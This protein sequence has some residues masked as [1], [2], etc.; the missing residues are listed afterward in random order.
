[1]LASAAAGMAI[2]TAYRLPAET[3]DPLG[4][5]TLIGATVLNGIAS[6]S[7]ALMLQY[8][9]AEFLGLTTALRLLEIARPDAP[10]LQFFL[11]NAPGTYQHSL[12]VA[13]LAE[14]AAEKLG[15]DTLLVRV[16]ALYH[17]V[18]KAL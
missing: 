3:L 1:G 11:R 5:I 6:A 18:G 15:M 4:Y 2:V 10:L 9:L 17:D 13:N 12:Q 16:G 7:V 8:L 14:Q